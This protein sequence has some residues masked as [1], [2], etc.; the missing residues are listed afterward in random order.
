[1]AALNPSYELNWSRFL[2]RCG[3]LLEQSSI[4]GKKVPMLEKV[5]IENTNQSSRLLLHPS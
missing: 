5:P 3:A 1:M 4:A 2:L